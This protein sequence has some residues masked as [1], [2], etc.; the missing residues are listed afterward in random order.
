MASDA[1]KKPLTGFSART[2]VTLPH[3]FDESGILVVYINPTSSSTGAYVIVSD[4][5]SAVFSV[6]SGGTSGTYCLPITANKTVSQTSISNCTVTYTF[7]P[8]T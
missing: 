5:T 2:V 1:I 7:A 3:R 8:L 6:P 4:G